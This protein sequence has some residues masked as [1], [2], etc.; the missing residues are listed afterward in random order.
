[1]SWVTAVDV[2]VTVVMVVS[3]G[4]V[5]VGVCNAG[6][7]RFDS[8]YAGGGGSVIVRACWHSALLS[9]GSCDFN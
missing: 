9:L 7:V 3:R 5:F 8:W 1:M 2:E 6:R 4:S